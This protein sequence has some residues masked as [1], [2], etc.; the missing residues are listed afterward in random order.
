MICFVIHLTKGYHAI[1]DAVDSDLA[2]YKW[3]AKTTLQGGVYAARSTRV[4]R[5]RAHVL[6]HRL[7]LS[8]KLGIELTREQLTD[9][10]DLDTLNNR[11]QNLRLATSAQ[12]NRNTGIGK[13]NKSGVIGVSWHARNNKWAA[14]I[15]VDSKTRYLGTFDDLAD[16]IA[17]RRAAEVQYFGEFAPPPQAN[18]LDLIQQD[19]KRPRTQKHRYADARLRS[20]NKSGYKGVWLTGL[21]KKPYAADCA[22]KHLGTFATA[23]E[24][25]AA[26]CVAYAEHYGRDINALNLLDESGSEPALREVERKQAQRRKGAK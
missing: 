20:D 22:G 19:A 25:Y 17:A 1:V 4:N 11:R 13:L 14:Y 15:S 12:N 7:I 24:A 5:Q 10:R 3:T 26:Y 21:R 18:E 6:M 23:E 9:H 16:A 8:R 2:Q